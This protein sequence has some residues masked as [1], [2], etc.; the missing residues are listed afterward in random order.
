MR[1]AILVGGLPPLYNG[2]T[3]NATVNIAKYAAKAGHEV[4]VIAANSYSNRA[5]TYSALQEGFKIH[6]ILTI[7]PPYLHG[8]V[9][10]PPAVTKI[11]SLKPDLI[12]A[13]AMYMCPSALIANKI[14]G[15]PYIF[16]ERGGVNQKSIWRKPLYQ[17]FMRNAKRVIAQT[18]D[19]RRTLLS[20]VQR[21]IEVIPNGIELERFGKVGKIQ[22][23]HLLG[24]PPN[25]KV[26]LSVGRCRVEKNLKNFVKCA[27]LRGQEVNQYI[28]V[29]DG[30]ELEELKRM[31]TPNVLFTGS[32]KNEDIP[33]YMSAADILVNTSHFEGFPNVFLEGMATGLPIIAPRVSG[34]PE[35]IEEGVNGILTKPD[36]YTSTYEAIEYLLRSY[37]VTDSMSRMNKLKAKRYTWENVVRRLYG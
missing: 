16:F 17:L 4:H 31:A 5:V 14:L 22:A 8:L 13:Q 7:N 27:A 26:I 34:I 35:I 18:D 29:G 36:D 11:M 20:L 6:C 32:V 9:Y 37:E 1:I 19:Q 2:G 33:K 12:H 3:E 15:I 24:L 10:I 25:K 21:D 30:P 23:R 28:L